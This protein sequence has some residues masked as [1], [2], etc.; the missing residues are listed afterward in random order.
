MPTVLSHEEERK[1]KQRRK[2]AN[3]AVEHD[4]L[5]KH[6][7][8]QDHRLR[9]TRLEKQAAQ[10]KRLADAFDPR[11]A[12]R[13]MYDDA[14]LAM[15]AQ[16]PGPGTYT[17]RLQQ[18]DS[19]G[20]TFGASPFVSA[21]GG[22]ISV[23]YDRDAGSPDAWKVKTAAQQPGPASYTPTS[24]RGACGSTFGLPPELRGEK[25]V[26]S[27]HDMGKMVAHLRDLPG[28]GAHSPRN[29]TEKNKGFRMV[30]SKAQTTLEY[31]IQEAGK[32]PGPG[33]YDLAASLSSGRSTVLAGGGLVKSELEQVMERSKEVPGPG[34]YPHA[35]Q[36]RS[37]GSPRFS[38]A[39]GL[40]LIEAIQKEAKTLPG[41]AAYHPTPTFAEEQATRRYMRK[42]IK[43]ENTPAKR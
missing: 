11:P 2:E 38:S 22:G 8:E 6:I 19:S 17:P 42:V 4:A 24:P 33:K 25:E 10:Q 36:L 29:P 15:A 31:V 39:G 28:P 40:S 14:V 34:A 27:A 13:K 20:K 18:K 41:P 26:P 1:L 32:V 9:L 35:S 7:Q 43:G 3:Q 23:V 37:K 30:P 16:V 12:R 5:V 21:S